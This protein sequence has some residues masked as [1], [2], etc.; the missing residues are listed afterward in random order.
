[1]RAGIDQARRMRPFIPDPTSRCS[2][3][4]CLACGRV[5]V[6]RYRHDFVECGCPNGTFCDGGDV[7]L[8]IGAKDLDRVEI[9][10][11]PD[12]PRGVPLDLLLQAGARFAKGLGC[13]FVPAS[14]ASWTEVEEAVAW[15]R[16]SLRLAAPIGNELRRRFAALGRGP[17]AVF[18]CLLS[19]RRSGKSAPEPCT[20]GP[21][22]P[23]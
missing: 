18:L 7:Y 11:S 2:S 1:L 23:R 20:A 21:S 8:R 12:W 6:S 16:A 22:R 15:L 3:V 17:G 4:R 19:R 14:D 9:L 10:V 13:D 5:L